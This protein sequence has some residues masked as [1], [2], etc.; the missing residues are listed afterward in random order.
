L[1]KIKYYK[2]TKETLL[3]QIQTILNIYFGFYNMNPRRRRRKER[4]KTPT[5]YTVPLILDLTW[6]EKYKTIR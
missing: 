1:A 3:H 5:N 6:F 2:I 4:K